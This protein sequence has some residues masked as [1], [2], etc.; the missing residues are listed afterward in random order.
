[1]RLRI[2]AATHT[3]RVRDHNE[4]AYVALAHH[5]PFVVCDGMGG[6][7]AGE[8]ASRIAVDTIVAELRPRRTNRAGGAVNGF[9]P[10]TA[11]LAEA[12]RQSN[13]CVYDRGQEDRRLAGMG[14]TVVSAWVE[15]GVASLA[16]VGD[17]RAYLWHAGRLEQLTRDHSLVEAQIR[18]G[19]VSREHS[20]HSAELNLLLRALGR[21]PDVEVELAE[22]AVQPGDYLLLCSDGLTRMVDEAAMARAIVQLQAPQQIADSLTEAANRNGGVDNVTVLVVA[23]T[24][25]WWADLRDRW[26]R[27]P[28]SA[29]AEAGPAV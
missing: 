9:L 1:M 19:L 26:R 4:D 20:R 25:G 24:R 15:G 27:R 2:G 23:V 8:I 3:G 28:R 21:D 16:H 12:V 17:S 10:Q 13:R 11:R 29:H 14:T 18:A 6:A 5:G 7:A 22:V